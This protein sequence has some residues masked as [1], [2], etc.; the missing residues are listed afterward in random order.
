MIADLF[1]AFEKALPILAIIFIAVF[2]LILLI[3]LILFFLINRAY[4]RYLALKKSGKSKLL[5]LPLGKKHFLKKEE[6]LLKIKSEIPQAHSRVKAELRTKQGRQQIKNQSDKNYELLI[7]QE[8]ERDKKELSEVNIVDI[9]KPI[10]RWTAMI[11]GQKLTYLIQAAQIL[12]KRGDR[13]FW[14]SM[15]EAKEREAG[16]QKSR[17]R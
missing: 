16:R 12:N 14:V 1:T 7:S 15:I 9:V 3:R 6:E 2:S 5:K 17:G 11:L 10:G 13:G 4:N 8:Q